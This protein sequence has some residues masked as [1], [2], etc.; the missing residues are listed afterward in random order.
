MSPLSTEA[1]NPF[2]TRLRAGELTLMLGIRSGRTTDVV[3]IAHAT[4]HH[5]ILVDL[6]HSAMSLDVATQLCAAAADLGMTPFVRVPEQ[7]Y[8]AI[9]RLLDGG[10]HG[11]V[12]PR[13]ETVDEAQAISR[14][15]RFPP[16][17]Q[18]SQLAM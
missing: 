13:V 6:E 4:G 11:I 2:V 10:A 5:S 17:G 9:G 8:G 12:A 18:R 15:C 1:Q 7:T 16:R 3:R 14:A